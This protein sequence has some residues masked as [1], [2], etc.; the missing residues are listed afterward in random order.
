M[1]K[2][3]CS[4]AMGKDTANNVYYGYA[5]ESGTVG[6]H[7]HQWKAHPLGM[8]STG[9]FDAGLAIGVEQMTIPV[10]VENEA[11]AQ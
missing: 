4:V 8:A 10:G 7:H 1:R 11:T 6:R 2:K 9:H 5:R 3:Y